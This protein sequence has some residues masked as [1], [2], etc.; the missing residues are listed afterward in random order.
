MVAREDVVIGVQTQFK[1]EDNKVIWVELAARA[2]RD[3]DGNI[4][5]YEGALEDITDRK[6]AEEALRESEAKYRA[7]IEQSLQGYVIFQ[8]ERVILANSRILEILHVSLEEIQKWAPSDIWEVVH[9]DDRP[10]L[11]QRLQD[12]FSGKPVL[13]RYDFRIQQ[14]DGT[15]TWLDVDIHLIDY[16]GKLAVQAALMDIT[17]RKLA[18]DALRESEAKFRNVVEQ[19]LQG[20]V[21]SQGTPPRIYFANEAFCNMIGYTIEE[22][23]AMPP[24]KVKDMIHPADR[25]FVL[26]RVNDRLKGK[27]A[28]Q[29]YEYRML[30][31]DGTILWVEVFATLIEFEGVP[32]IQAAYVDITER[33]ETEAALQESE[34]KF[35]AL[36]EE[37]SDW[38]WEMDLQGKI[39][40]S[41]NAVEDI[42]G[43]S[44]GQVVGRTPCD[45][46]RPEDVNR[47]QQTFNELKEKKRPIRTLVINFVHRDE[48][49]VMLEARGRPVLNEEGELIGFRGICR[50]ITDRLKMIEQLRHL[51]EG[52]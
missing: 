23:L 9:P 32:A 15:I 24:K 33:K 8:D 50:D 38:V 18:D 47:A 13:D 17:E 30:R 19:S 31:K 27:P 44:A 35:R 37:L 14:E 11:Q 36:V 1:R 29:Q 41:N 34:E 43:F 52:M 42:L 10:I 28:P 51:E 25:E 20:I 4:L 12:R 6:Q 49:D 2:I 7:V 46:L 45:F 3:S 39:L 21:I 48:S 40:Y 5:R 16:Q 22:L 26:Q